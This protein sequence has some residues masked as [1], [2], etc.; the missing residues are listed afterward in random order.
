MEAKIEMSDLKKIL[1]EKKNARI[2]TAIQP[3]LKQMA[4]RKAK[5]QNTDLSS[6]INEMLVAF[7][8]A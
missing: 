1:A 3:T 7:V 4:M 2:D 6:I 5:E 8:A